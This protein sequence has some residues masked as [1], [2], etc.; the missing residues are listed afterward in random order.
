[1]LKKLN[2]KGLVTYVQIDVK[3]PFV[4][5]FRIMCWLPWGLRVPYSN[6]RATVDIVLTPFFFT[7]LRTSNRMVERE[8]YCDR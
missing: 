5:L 2:S 3:L 7:F 8:K 1:M 6:L 4:C